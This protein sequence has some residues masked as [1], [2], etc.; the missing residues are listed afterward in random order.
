MLRLRASCWGTPILRKTQSRPPPP[1]A[2]GSHPVAGAACPASPRLTAPYLHVGV[3]KAAGR[4]VVGVHG[5]RLLLGG[6]VLIFVKRQWVHRTLIIQTA[7]MGR[8]KRQGVIPAEQWD[9]RTLSFMQTSQH[10]PSIP[11]PCTV[12]FPRPSSPKGSKASVNQKGQY[13]EHARS[14]AWLTDILICHL[15]GRNREPFECKLRCS[16]FSFHTDIS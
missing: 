8:E 12:A 7:A 16:H 5:N 9:K 1:A 4:Q 3:G 2:T 13:S 6:H 11:V 15:S 14:F 10:W